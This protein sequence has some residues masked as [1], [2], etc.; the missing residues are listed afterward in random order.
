[1][2]N[3]E[4]EGYG[5]SDRLVA[6]GEAVLSHY[7]VPGMR[8]GHRKSPSSGGSGGSSA[9]PAVK[10][11]RPAAPPAQVGRSKRAVAKDLA[12]SSVP[13]LKLA[14]K[15]AGR[16]AAVGALTA[17]GVPTVVAA[18]T[19]AAAI[20][21]HPEIVKAGKDFTELWANEAGFHKMGTLDKLQKEINVKQTFDKYPPFET[22]TTV[23]GVVQ[24]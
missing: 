10:K 14:A 17:V 4:S 2:T 12:K 8:W 6:A 1:M 9:A 3:H 24:K 18:G 15:A 5:A 11:A 19:V 16:V 20:A 21:A 7:G 13:V 22:T 23:N